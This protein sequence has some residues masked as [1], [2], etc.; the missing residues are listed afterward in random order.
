MPC[1]METPQEDVCLGEFP[2]S[3]VQLQKGLFTS[4][5]VGRAACP[6]LRQASSYGGKAARRKSAVFGDPEP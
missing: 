3:H 4:A 6:V 1:K 5:Q 2:D